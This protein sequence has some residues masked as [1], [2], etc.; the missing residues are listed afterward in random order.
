[1]F[2]TV[3]RAE[4]SGLTRKSSSGSNSYSNR[5]GSLKSH[6]ARLIITWAVWS[7]CVLVL[8]KAAEKLPG[9]IPDPLGLASRGISAPPLARW[10]SGWYYRIIVDG[11]RNDSDSEGSVGFYPLYPVLVEIQNGRSRMI[12]FDRSMRLPLEKIAA[13]SASAFFLTSPNA[14]T[15]IAFAN[16]ELEQILTSFRG[17]LVVDVK[18]ATIGNFSRICGYFVHKLTSQS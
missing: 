5:E 4:S 16:T 8:A 18:G 6:A 12:E 11:Y 1:M 3:S 14:P 2:S 15:G 17:L 13:S 7:C 10:D 9:E